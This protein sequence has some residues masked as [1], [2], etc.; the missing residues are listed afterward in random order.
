MDMTIDRKAAL[1]AYKERRVPIGIFAVRCA[2]TGEV[3]AGRSPNL[4]TIKNRIWFGLRLG[5]L[6]VRA[7]QAAWAA[8]GEG[9][10]SFEVVERLDTNDGAEVHEVDLKRRLA[11]WRDRLGA[12]AA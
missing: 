5:T 10:F 12:D 9:S 7:M 2:A 8:H 11:H 3:W 1:A 6:H 4:D